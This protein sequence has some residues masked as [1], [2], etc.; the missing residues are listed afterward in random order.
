MQPHKKCRQRL[1]IGMLFISSLLS[2]C[3][4]QQAISRATPGAVDEDSGVI[5]FP[6]TE[7]AKWV[8][9]ISSLCILVEQSYPTIGPS[10]TQPIGEELQ[11]IFERIG[12]AASLGAGADCQATLTIK[13]EIT[14][15]AQPVSGAGECFLDA[16]ATGEA[17]ISSPGQ[18][19]AEMSLSV[20][21]S[22]GGGFRIVYECPKTP[23]EGPIES[24]WIQAVGPVLSEWWGGPALVSMLKSEQYYVRFRG[25]RLLQQMGLEASGA[26]PS[27]IEMLNDANPGTRAAAAEALG[28]FGESA[29][30]AVPAL[31]AALDDSDDGARYAAVLALGKIG[32]DQALQALIKAL[33]HS[34]W[35]TRYEAA[36]ALA[37]MG[38]EAAPAIPDL[39][40][41]I[42]DQEMQVG[43]SAI[44]ALGDIGPA[45]MQAVPKLIELLASGEDYYHSDAEYAL[46]KITGQDFGED[47]AAWKKWWDVQQ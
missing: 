1:L 36:E 42:D 10:Y 46:E 34:D 30:E 43:S 20:P 13:L 31:V 2:A 14:P 17:S 33:H 44:G 29:V 7:S 45:A 47:A 27:L 9:S 15:I 4:L 18:D 23:A 41:A 28:E 19:T 35:Y 22:K 39:I 26:L 3:S 21:A 37:S 5:H 16:E 8:K 25:I 24:T 38:P 11:G 6:K 40:E 32:G 12:V